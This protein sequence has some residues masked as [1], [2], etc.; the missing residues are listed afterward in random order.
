[1]TL[2]SK[3]L[4]T[5][6][7]SAKLVSLR[8]LESLKMTKCFLFFLMLSNRCTSLTQS[9][10]IRWKISRLASSSLVKAILLLLFSF[11][12]FLLWWR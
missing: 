6:L 7:S 3:I 11:F 1:M 12:F 4:S 10:V 2:K 5:T 9:S 8:L